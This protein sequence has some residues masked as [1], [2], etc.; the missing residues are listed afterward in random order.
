MNTSKR[1]L[2]HHTTDYSRLVRAHEVVRAYLMVCV[3]AE[4]EPAA[5]VCHL[6]DQESAAD[7]KWAEAADWILEFDPR[8][9]LNVF[10]G[11][12]DEDYTD[13]FEGQADEMDARLPES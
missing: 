3:Q 2:H 1:L 10:R 13:E 11:V 7:R 5:M 6:L 12:V 8:P 4:E 9:Y